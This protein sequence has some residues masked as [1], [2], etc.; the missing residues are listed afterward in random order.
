MSATWHSVEPSEIR[1]IRLER[2][3]VVSHNEL[4]T[5][6][7]GSFIKESV[8]VIYSSSPFRVSTQLML[9]CHCGF[10]EGQQLSYS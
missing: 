5:E 2:L 3:V 7:V 4:R 6:Y 10:T 8:V 9:L 1:S